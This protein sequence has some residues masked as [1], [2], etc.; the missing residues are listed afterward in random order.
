MILSVSDGAVAPAAAAEETARPETR[1]KQ[2]R[3][4]CNMVLPLRAANHR[5]GARLE[6]GLTITPPYEFE[7]VNEASTRSKF[8]KSIARTCRGRDLTSSTPGARNA[9]IS[10]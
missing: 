7:M 6:I 1:A 2:S 10:R 9:R 5:S 8:W 3:V 4:R